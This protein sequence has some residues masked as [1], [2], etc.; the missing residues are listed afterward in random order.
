M[1][2][3]TDHKPLSYILQQKELS[4]ALNQWIDIL[5]DYTFEIK[6][7]E[8][9]L[10]I[11]PDFLSRLYA[12]EYSGSTWGVPTGREVPWKF[13]ADH[14]IADDGLADTEMNKYDSSNNVGVNVNVVT[15]EEV[16]A[17][18]TSV[19]AEPVLSVP[20]QNIMGE[21]NA[22]PAF[23]L[24]TSDDLIDVMIQE[25]RGITIPKTQQERNELVSQH[26]LFGHFGR[27]AMCKSLVRNGYWWR[28][29]RND[30]V[31]EIAN[32]D[33]CNR[34]TV[35]RDGFNPSGSI[36]ADGP[37]SHIQVD[38]SVHLP[39]APG[40]LKVL[41]VVIDVFTGYIILRALKRSTAE[42]VAMSLWEIFCIF[43]LPRIIQSDNGTEFCNDVI[44]S[45]MKLINIDHRF[46]S[47]YNPRSDGKVERS[48]RTTMSIIK[49]LL[50]GNEENW[51]LF[52]PFAQLSFN[53]KVSSLTGSTPFSL[54]FGRNLNPIK[55]YTTS[56]EG[57]LIDLQQ[58]KQHMEQIQSL[59]YPA[60]IERVKDKKSK[61]IQYL[62]KKRKVLL[63][64]Y[65]IGAVVMLKD[66]NKTDKFQPKYVG[67]YSIIKRTRNG[68]YKLRDETG[69]ELERNVP[70]DQLKLI[71]TKPR[72]E[73]HNN[74]VYEVEQILDHRGEPGNYE[75]KVKWKFYKSFTWEPEENFRDVTLIRDY[76]STKRNHEDAN[77]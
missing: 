1:V 21:G 49:K 29:M 40:G 36:T 76:W 50:H 4:P 11:L 14:V 68:N 3:F 60:I 69:E 48:I 66:P 6:Y 47:P 71:S 39:A 16:T 63:S 77:N 10:N 15:I 65:P 70:P 58:W 57:T 53:N 19:I 25:Q 26:H 31:N 13:P 44:R 52:V 33:A 9:K 5:L 23:N 20:E 22:I 7:R 12:A 59:I 72:K 46:I 64:P 41:L 45:L 30:V 73:D 75:Y 18:D 17:S 74:N 28:G 38:T 27:D 32:C 62:D 35:V 55:D 34:F 51:T 67:P 42:L 37:W 24:K 56:Y 43:G 61:M 2:I 54:M 8:G